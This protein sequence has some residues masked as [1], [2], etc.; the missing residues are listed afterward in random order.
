MEATFDVYSRGADLDRS[1]R[2]SGQESVT[3]LK[4]SGLPEL[5]LAHLRSRRST[6]ARIQGL[7]KLQDADIVALEEALSK[8]EARMRVTL[9]G[10]MP[11]YPCA[12]PRARV[13]P[14]SA[15]TIAHRDVPRQTR[16][17]SRSRGSRRA[18]PIMATAS[19]SPSS[20]RGRTARAEPHASRHHPLLG[21]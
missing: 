12:T 13:L 2:I 15:L 9:Q 20:T 4:G 19:P 14:A 17:R 8:G 7:D 11:R 10:Q 6:S 1:D 18:T 5:V 21:R 3:F 16:S